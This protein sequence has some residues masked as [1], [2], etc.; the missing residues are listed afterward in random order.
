[1]PRNPRTIVVGLAIVAV[2]VAVLVSFTGSGGSA[3]DPGLK[4]SAVRLQ[5]VLKQRDGQYSGNTFLNSF[6]LFQAQERQILQS[7]APRIVKPGQFAQITV[8]ETTT[9]PPVWQN[10]MQRG[11][12]QI[13]LDGNLVTDVDGGKTVSTTVHLGNIAYRAF[14]T[15]LDI[16]PSLRSNNTHGILAVFTRA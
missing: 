7:K 9:M 6:N 12:P 1:M 10:M 4:Q 2:L 15:P 16:P 3:A 13:P 5:T 11:Q 14:L 8:W